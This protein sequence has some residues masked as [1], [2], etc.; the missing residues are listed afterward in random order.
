MDDN[1]DTLAF[2]LKALVSP[3]NCFIS[4]WVNT[5][6]EGT[7]CCAECYNAEDY[8]EDEDD[9][10]DL[11]IDESEPMAVIIAFKWLADRGY[12]TSEKLKR[13]QDGSRDIYL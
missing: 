6:C 1:L 4:S 11:I 3:Y 5:D 9:T 12:L 7:H 8:I 2:R 13:F 10:W